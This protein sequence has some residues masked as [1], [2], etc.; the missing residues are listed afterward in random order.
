MKGNP[1]IIMTL[2]AILSQELAAINQYVVHSAID[3][4]QLYNKLAKKIMHRAQEEMKHADLI[5]DRI[6]F[7]EG[8]PIVSNLAE[9]NIGIDIAAQINNDI[10]AEQIAIN[11][12]NKAI[13]Q[14]EESLDE[15]TRKLLS[16]NLKDEEEHLN[17]LEGQLS[18]LTTLG[19]ENFLTEQ[20]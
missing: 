2:N 18:Q 9:I 20:I 12:Y 19:K 1:E 4:N 17:Y 13:D 16:H 7:L 5:I 8:M 10:K 3:A 15:G 11:I 14:A 6:L